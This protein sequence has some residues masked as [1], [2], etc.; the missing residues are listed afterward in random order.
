VMH[1]KVFAASRSRLVVNR[2][3][4]CLLPRIPASGLGTYKLPLRVDTGN[5]GWRTGWRQPAMNSRWSPRFNLLE[6]GR[7]GSN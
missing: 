1:I 3:I 4:E 2:D 6:S 5:P 7:T